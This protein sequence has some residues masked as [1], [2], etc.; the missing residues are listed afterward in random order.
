VALVAL[1]SLHTLQNEKIKFE[2]SH[3]E[4]PRVTEECVQSFN[5]AAQVCLSVHLGRI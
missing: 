1:A 5:V 4:L 3:N 2:K